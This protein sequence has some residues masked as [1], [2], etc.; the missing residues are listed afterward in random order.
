[1]DK[2]K[3]VAKLNRPIVE[4]TVTEPVKIVVGTKQ[5]PEF[6]PEPVIEPKQRLGIKKV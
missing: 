2:V 6:Q 1:M 4:S 3:R 5:R